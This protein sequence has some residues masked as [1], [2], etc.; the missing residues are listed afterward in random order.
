MRVAGFCQG[1]LL[2]LSLC[3]AFISL[4]PGYAFLQPLQPAQPLSFVTSIVAILLGLTSRQIAC[5]EMPSPVP[6]KPKPSSVV[7]FTFTWLMSIHNA[8]AILALI[9]SM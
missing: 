5:E 3:D 8:F 1:I 4:V 9:S 7:A 6:V 2:S